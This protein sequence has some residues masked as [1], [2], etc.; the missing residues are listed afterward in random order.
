MISELLIEKNI[1]ENVRDFA[2]KNIRTAQCILE[3]FASVFRVQFVGN[4]VQRA[5]K[6]GKESL[7]N[8]SRAVDPHLRICA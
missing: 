2:T 4:I 3:E 6:A 1:L 8:M 7:G 5:S